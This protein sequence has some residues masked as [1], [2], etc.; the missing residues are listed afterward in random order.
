MPSFVPR[1]NEPYQKRELF[2]K[3]RLALRGAVNAGATADRVAGTA[4]KVRLAALAVITAERSL[5]AS[6]S[7]SDARTRQSDNLRRDEE[8]WLGLS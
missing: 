7:V 4:E 6:R 3:R 5:L 8:R 1:S 2:D